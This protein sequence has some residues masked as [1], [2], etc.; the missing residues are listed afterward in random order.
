MALVAPSILSADF[1]NLERDIKIV[2]EAGADWI[3]VDVMD[4]LF[5]P[6]IT[7]GSPV[8]KSIRKVT[9]LPLDVHLM[10]TNPEKHIKDFIDAGA[11]IITF[12]LEAT[13]EGRQISSQPQ[14][15]NGTSG[16]TIDERFSLV[17]KHFFEMKNSEIVDKDLFLK[18]IKDKINLI[19]ELGAKAG[20]SINPGTDIE[21]LETIIKDIDMVLL[22]SVH[23][24]FGGQQFIPIVFD[25]IEQIKAMASKNQKVIGTN[26]KHGELVIEVDGGVAPGE[27]ANKLA[28]AGFNALVAGSAIYK[29]KDIPDTISKLKDPLKN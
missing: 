14:L 3:H 18:N 27:T 10:I 1:S 12:H 9:N 6:N 13:L 16:S 7:I 21:V 8:V 25:K 2:E 24:G 11:D 19:H 4:G 26:I 28:K 5:V 23:P 22:M 17:P 15:E 20:I 29:S